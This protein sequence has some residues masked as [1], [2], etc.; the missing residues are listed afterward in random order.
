MFGSAVLDVAIG[1][2]FVFLLVGLI[3]SQVGDK[4]A[5][6]LRWR[7][8][9][10]EKGLR[11]YILGEERTDLLDAIYANPLVQ[12]VAP[13]DMW[14]TKALRKIPWVDRLVH[15]GQRPT[16][17]SS[18]MFVT[19]LTKV[20]LPDESGETDIEKLRAAIATMPSTTPM[21]G[22]LLFIIDTANGKIETARKGIEEWYDNA[23]NKTT[24]VY[25]R[26]MWGFSL[27]IVVLVAVFLNVDTIAVG[28]NLWN[29]S[30]LRTAL[31]NQATKYAQ[32]TPE[33][34]KAMQELSSLNLP[35]GW[36]VTVRPAFS[37]V[38]N[39]WLPKPGQAATPIGLRAYVL[40]IA[41]W[42]ITA[43]AGAQGAPFWFDLLRKLTQKG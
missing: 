42:L 10:L 33:Q 23:I 30:A 20:L 2:V 43:L 19:A 9:G 15:T 35:I 14:V 1:L 16:W 41:G 22:S 8:K 7:A 17:I 11:K 12:S 36:R 3:C 21:R 25:Q 37:A 4:I 5:Q 26:N 34:A 27:L 28:T 13:E 38:P 39:D 29:D 24:A 6:W 18:K 31:V 40:K 32:G